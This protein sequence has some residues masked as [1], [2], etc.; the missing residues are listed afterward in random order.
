MHN[1]IA[2]GICSLCGG[3][4]MVHKLW[5]SVVPDTPTCYQCGAKKESYS[6]SKVSLP[7]ITMT[8]APRSGFMR[9]G[10]KTEAL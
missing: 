4:V 2:I 10:N 6:E 5:G 9:V 3:N 8:P 7:I 1:M